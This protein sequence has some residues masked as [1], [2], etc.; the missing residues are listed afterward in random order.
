MVSIKESQDQA[1]AFLR[2]L[3]QLKESL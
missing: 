3:E 2:R 1:T